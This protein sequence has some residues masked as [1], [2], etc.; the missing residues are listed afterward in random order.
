[1]SSA[2]SWKL[3]VLLSTGNGSSG[4]SRLAVPFQTTAPVQVCVNDEIVRVDSP[5]H[6]CEIAKPTFLGSGIVQYLTEVFVILTLVPGGSRAEIHSESYSQNDP[7]FG[8]RQY[9][10]TAAR[11][12]AISIM[13]GDRIVA[14]GGSPVIPESTTRRLFQITAGD[15]VHIRALASVYAS[16][17]GL[18]P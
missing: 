11:P 9:V 8:K 16:M 1:M 15:P 13:P 14:T 3:N 10:L 17:V 2:F 4:L 12:R 6:I 5:N 18:D 7:R